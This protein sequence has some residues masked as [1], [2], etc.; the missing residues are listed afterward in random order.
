MP[1]NIAFMSFF[2]LDASGEDERL[3]PYF[4]DKD[5]GWLDKR[6]SLFPVSLAGFWTV[7][8]RAIASA[9]DSESH[10]DCFGGLEKSTP[11]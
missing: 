11:E 1:F 3:S 5:E 9:V 10:D 4:P 6:R 7:Q 2:L 8:V